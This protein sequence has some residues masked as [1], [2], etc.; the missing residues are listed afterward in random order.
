MTT[1]RRIPTVPGTPRE[2]PSLQ[3]NRREKD[4]HHA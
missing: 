1:T 4:E 2:D 3:E